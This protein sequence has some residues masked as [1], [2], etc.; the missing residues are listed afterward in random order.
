[1]HKW[2]KHMISLDLNRR[3]N[4]VGD[5]SPVPENES[6]GEMTSNKDI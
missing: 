5:Q 6:E 3:I 4:W 2:K 1:M